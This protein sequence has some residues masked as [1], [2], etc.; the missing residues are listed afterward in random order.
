MEMCYDGAL[1]MPSSYAVMDEEEMMYVEGGFSW[2]Q[3]KTLALG[4]LAVV[5]ACNTIM[6]MFN[7]AVK[8]GAAI[9]GISEAAF[10]KGVATKVAATIGRI[11][12]WVS[13]YAGVVV[14]VLATLVAF[15]GGY[16]AG[17]KVSE[18]VFSRY[19]R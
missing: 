12:A 8:Y 5:G 9:K 2:S 4:V 16:Y 17:K 18:Q 7:N 10:I 15:A 1:V 3:A 6:T 14:A 19:H 13:K 11:T